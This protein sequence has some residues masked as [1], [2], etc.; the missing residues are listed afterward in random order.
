MSVQNE[1][2]KAGILWSRGEVR[3][4]VMALRALPFAPQQCFCIFSLLGR[5]LL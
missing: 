5:E 3:G 4:L 1:L 2:K